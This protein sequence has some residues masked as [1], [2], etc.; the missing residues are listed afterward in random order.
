VP[1]VIN[2]LLEELQVQCSTCKMQMRRESFKDHWDKNCAWGLVV[3]KRKHPVTGKIC[4]KCLV[5]NDIQNHTNVC[6]HLSWEAA[7]FEPLSTLSHIEFNDRDNIISDGAPSG[8]QEETPNTAVT[9]GNFGATSKDTLGPSI[10][11]LTTMKEGVVFEYFQGEFES[12]PDFSSLTP[13]VFNSFGDPCFLTNSQ[14]FGGCRY[15]VELL[16]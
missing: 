9:E 3:C 12:I 13:K 5:R 2:T 11:D 15:L 1:Y 7:D 10:S 8:S 14:T 4:G 6:S 16:H